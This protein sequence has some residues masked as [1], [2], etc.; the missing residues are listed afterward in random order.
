MRGR[1]F[2]LACV[3]TASL[4]YAGTASAVA[5]ERIPLSGAGRSGPAGFPPGVFLT[6]VSPPQYVA[7][8]PGRW[9]GP[10]YWASGNPTL[11]ARAVID[12]SVSFRDRS[13]EPDSAAAA[14]T[15]RGWREQERAGIAVPHV[16]GPNVVGTLPSYFVLKYKDAA[17]ETA[18]A[19][20]ISATAI[21]IVKF[22]LNAPESSSAEGAG[23]FVVQG[24]FR[25]SSWNRGQAFLA[26]S[27]V[28][29]E[30]TLPP[31]KVSIEAVRRKLAVRGTVVD[32]FQHAIVGA[33]VVLQRRSGLAWRAVGSARTDA[34]GRYTVATGGPGRY[35]VSVAR[36]RLRSGSVPVRK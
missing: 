3:A 22:S 34:Q 33:R 27:G 30:G 17:H 15:Q 2:L 9:V 32:A 18:L 24:S 25:A 19:V 31:A 10:E 20:P 29:L 16:A 8:G 12:W 35:R 1:A 4:V 36:T 11:R 6:L 13:V 23:D 14:A 26:L 5:V 28:K 21:A 7:A